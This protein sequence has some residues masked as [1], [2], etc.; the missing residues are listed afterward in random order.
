MK[1]CCCGPDAVPPSRLDQY[2]KKV[3]G[4]PPTDVP[5]V[6]LPMVLCR[7]ERCGRAQNLTCA[8]WFVDRV[9]GALPKAAS[10]EHQWTQEL[11]P[12][13]ERYCKGV[14]PYYHVSVSHCIS[15]SLTPIIEGARSSLLPTPAPLPIP[16]QPVDG[17]PIAAGNRSSN[18]TEHTVHNVRRAMANAHTTDEVDRGVEGA[19]AGPALVSD[20]EE[21]DSE[22]SDS[23]ES[24]DDS[25]FEPDAVDVA[26]RPVGK[27][28]K[29]RGAI[30]DGIARMKSLAASQPDDGPLRELL[31][32][33]WNCSTKPPAWR[34]MVKHAF[35]QHERRVKAGKDVPPVVLSHELEGAL[36]VPSHKV[37]ITSH[38][39]NKNLKVDVHGTPRRR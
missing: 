5:T 36:A 16:G 8:M 10:S 32:G 20:D 3:G 31:Q 15:C 13:Y 22:E 39:H 23:E 4:P 12:T 17:P 11:L 29:R 26:A 2:L 7:N 34:N 28:L 33:Y 35:R 1:C 37:L 6:P 27:G 18:N 30:R 25:D 38:T 21:S 19:M 9:L 24:E 14:Y